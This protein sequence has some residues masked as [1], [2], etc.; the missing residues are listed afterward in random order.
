MNKLITFDD[1]LIEP[2]YSEINSRSE[3]DLTTS[4]GGNKYSIPVVSANMDTITGVDMAT[5]MLSCGAAACLHRFMSIEATTDAFLL[6]SN[7]T[8][9]AAWIS[10]G[11][12]DYEFR[13]A[14]VLY[15]FGARTLVL[16]VAH[17]A[18]KQV[19][20]QYKLVKDACPEAFIIIGNF[21]NHDTVCDFIL[22]GCGYHHMSQFTDGIKIGIGPG[23]ACTT[24]IK[25]GVGI[26]QLSAIQDVA[27][28]KYNMKII[29]DGGMRSPGDIAK[30]L[31]AGADMCM[32]GGMLA[33]TSETPGDLIDMDSGEKV[34][35]YSG[36]FIHLRLGKKYRGSASKESYSVQGKD[37][38]YITAEGESFIVPYKG[39]VKDVLQDIT[40]GLKSA[41]TY[42]GSRT[43]ADF[44]KRAKFIYVSPG[45]AIENAAHGKKT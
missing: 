24:R 30:A 44:Q 41:F 19:A 1:V 28:V 33:G 45:T 36:D 26:P 12:G 40:G 43:L 2:R 42:T 35:G 39:Y 23:S 14:K 13:R 34:I 38:G 6:V 10:F 22:D 25:T 27:R 37:R 16:D 7:N 17:G 20:D 9:S 29:A 32:V 11:L 15:D 8:G 31:A 21:A 4:L 18:Q 3:V 5:A